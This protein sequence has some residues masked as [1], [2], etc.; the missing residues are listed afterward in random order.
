MSPTVLTEFET[1]LQRQR[2]L[3]IIRL[4]DPE[5]CLRLCQ[6][7]QAHGFPLLEITLTTPQALRLIQELAEAG[8]WIGAGTVLHAEAAR[9]ALAAGARFLVSPGLSL[10]IQ[11]VAQAAQ[12]PYIPGVMTP[13]E[14]MLALNHGLE[15]LKLFPASH[16]GCDYL[17]QLRGPFPQARW[18]P[19]G[20]I[21]WAQIAEWLS[22]GC[23]AVGQGT[24]L[25]SQTHLEA[26]DWAALA[27][28]IQGLQQALRGL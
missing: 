8:V 1:A 7:L 2:V 16:L 27:V 15:L 3:P 23:L 20:G 11:A 18:L 17:Q 22:A 28:E 25:V 19:T 12:V 21:A 10:E 4:S 9:Q 24:R 14:V 26:R 13:S 6:L 5:L